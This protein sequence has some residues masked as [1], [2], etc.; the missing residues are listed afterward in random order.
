MLA[1]TIRQ[2]AAPI[3]DLSVP[4]WTGPLA[5]ELETTAAAVASLDARISATFCQTAWA[6]RAAWSGYA[7]ALCGQGV[8][9]DEI[10]IFGQACGLPLPS[11]TRQST[12]GDDLSQLTEWQANLR[13]TARR[14]WREALPFTFDPP[15][16]WGSRPVLL[17][18]LELTARHARANRTSAPWL[19]MPALLN[20]LGATHNTLPNLVC[21]DKALRL[22]PGDCAAIVRRYLKQLRRAAETGLQRL[23]AIEGDRLRAA[24]A[25][26]RARRPGS[27]LP[28]LALVQVQPVLSPRAVAIRLRLTI[29]GAGKLLARAAASGL[30]VEVSGR[31]SWR[32][33]LPPDLAQSFGFVPARPGRPLAPPPPTPALD[34][35][36]SDF[37]AEMRA[38]DERLARLG[39]STAE[40]V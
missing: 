30:L 27:L 12:V 16:D 32:A 13:V 24:G 17:R 2:M 38:I 22:Q 19:A 11:R 15:S 7:E 21:P 20:A 29:S 31:Q 4:S 6:R 33:Y 9:I 35:V 40:A 36:L 25:L 3:P 34:A 23:D 39:L 10:D 1:A 18:A 28:L 14:H 8:E 37:D 5:H 26:S